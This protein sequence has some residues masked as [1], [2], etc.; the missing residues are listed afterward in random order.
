MHRVASKL[1]PGAA[2]EAPDAPGPD[3]GHES[4]ELRRRRDD[5]RW[6][7]LVGTALLFA[8]AINAYLAAGGAAMCLWGFG[9]YAYWSHRI[10]SSYD[11]WKDEELDRWEDE[12]YG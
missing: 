6:Y 10:R 5:A 3:P 2:V 11:P 9:S 1:A 12:H 8:G 4:R 7:V